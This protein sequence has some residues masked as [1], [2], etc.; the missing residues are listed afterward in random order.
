MIYSIKPEILSGKVNHTK[1]IEYL[2]ENGWNPFEIKQKNISIFQNIKYN[3]FYQVIVPKDK[4]LSDYADAMYCAIKEIADVA[5]EPI[6]QLLLKLLE[7]N[8]YTLILL[9]NID[10][11]HA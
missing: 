8:S 11:P 1:V 6:E 4:E 5:E 2:K 7:P 3:R 10:V 9:P